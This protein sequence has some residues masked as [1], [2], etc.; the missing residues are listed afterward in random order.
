MFNEFFGYSLLAAGAEVFFSEAVKEALV[1]TKT[2]VI[3]VMAV[4]VALTLIFIASGWSVASYVSKVG[5]YRVNPAAV[6]AS[7]VFPAPPT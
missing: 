1:P 3:V 6:L 5:V 2:V 4:V 7:V